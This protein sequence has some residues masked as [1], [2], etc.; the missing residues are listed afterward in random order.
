M[1][2][3]YCFIVGLS[4]LTSKTILLCRLFLASI[5]MSIIWYQIHSGGKDENQRPIA[6][7]L[8]CLDFWQN[9]SEQS[10]LM[11]TLCK[12]RRYRVIAEMNLDI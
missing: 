6:V 11:Y 4:E 10:G 3:I 12:S 9:R 1:K 2:K 7:I 5:S 8:F